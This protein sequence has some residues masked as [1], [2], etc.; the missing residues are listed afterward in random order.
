MRTVHWLARSGLRRPRA[1]PFP[2]ACAPGA[3]RAWR[4]PG[5]LG[6][7]PRRFV[8]VPGRPVGGVGGSVRRRCTLWW[9]AVG[10]CRAEAASRAGQLRG[11]ALCNYRAWREGLS[12]RRGFCAGGIVPGGQGRG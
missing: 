4:R 5:S 1:R 12:C 11:W 6:S 10:T 2:C 3:L 9:L 7:G 8:E